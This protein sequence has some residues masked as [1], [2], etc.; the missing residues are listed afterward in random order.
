MWQQGVF[1]L[2]FRMTCLSVISLSLWSVIFF[3]SLL[4]SDYYS[5]IFTEHSTWKCTFWCMVK[6]VFCKCR[7]DRWTSIVSGRVLSS[8]LSK[9]R[10][11]YPSIAIVFTSFKCSSLFSGWWVTFEG[12][13]MGCLYCLPPV[14]NDHWNQNHLNKT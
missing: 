14:L 13:T 12:V 2:Y 4:M 1:L 11:C 6:N 7:S 9:C 8:Q 3:S 10:I 5:V